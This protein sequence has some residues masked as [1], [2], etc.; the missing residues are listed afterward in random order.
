MFDGGPSSLSRL[1]LVAVASVVLMT[2]DHRA[3]HL[4]TVRSVLAT[5]VYPL[6]VAV[7]L[8][9]QA[10]N[11][12]AEHLS[13]RESLLEENSRLKARQLLLDSKLEK[14]NELEAEN[15]RLRNLLDSSAKVGERVLV[16]EL[17]SVDMD[18]FSRRIVLNKGTRD[19]VEAGQSLIDSN[20]VMGQVVHVAPF[21][22]SA[23]LITDPS[24]ALPVQV[25]RNGLR[26]IAVGTGPVNLLE[27][28][29]IPNNADVRIG[30]VLVTS[31]LGGRFPSGYP[32]GRVVNIERNRGRPFA[33][34]MVQPSARLERNREVLLVW[35][36]VA[37]GEP[38]DPTWHTNAEHPR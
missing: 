30:D 10:G 17:L 7:D 38:D 28:L 21:S 23:L 31:G 32:V 25:H 12:L 34:V 24:H 18:P 35:P 20:G 19:G 37:A 36:A 15:R 2:V 9:I 13:S 33:T 14:F 3:K 4:E 16:A 11:W 6:Q 26:A 29:H 27:L 5:V 1:V 22:S 8:P